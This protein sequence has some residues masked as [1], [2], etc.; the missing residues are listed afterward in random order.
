MNHRWEANV[1]RVWLLLA[2][3]AGSSIGFLVGWLTLGFLVANLLPEGGMH[4]D[5]VWIA[6]YVVGFA[7]GLLIGAPL[8]AAVGATIMLKVTRRR[9]SFRKGLLGAVVGLL[10]GLLIGYLTGTLC[11]WAPFRQGEWLDRWWPFAQGEWWLPY[12]VAIAVVY[13]TTVAGA[14]AGS[15]WKA[16]RLLKPTTERATE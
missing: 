16:K 5:F 2:R 12:C 3:I 14:V 7:L 10:T 6:K 4:P 1:K 9:S 13:V 15:G 8:G 11:L